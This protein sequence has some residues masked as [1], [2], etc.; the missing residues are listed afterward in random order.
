MRI[1]PLLA[2]FVRDVAVT[3]GTFIPD[4]ELRYLRTIHFVITHTT[5]SVVEI[6]YVAIEIGL[7]HAALR[8]F[9]S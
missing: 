9:A 1:S 7:Y 2:G 8:T 4:K 5:S 6:L 3:T